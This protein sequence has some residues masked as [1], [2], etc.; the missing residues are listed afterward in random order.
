MGENDYWSLLKG[1]ND[2]AGKARQLAEEKEVYLLRYEDMTL[3]FHKTFKSLLDWLGLNSSETVIHGVQEKTSFEAMTGR[4]PGEEANAVI[5]KGDICEW[6]GELDEDE[7]AKAW[8]IAGEN[9]EYFGY[10]TQG[11]IN[12]LKL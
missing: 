6:L 11:E 4:K 1:W 7:K 5:R 10:S 8:G 12:P 9:L 2:R 3:D